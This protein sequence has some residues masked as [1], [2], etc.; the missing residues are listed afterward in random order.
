M[1]NQE[2]EEKLRQEKIELLKMKQGCGEALEEQPR[3]IEKPRGFK[4]ISN[5]FYHY[6]TVF[7][8]ALAA[9]A[10]AAVFAVQFLVKE[11]ADITVFV[12]YKQPNSEL[13]EKYLNIAAMLEKYCPDFDGDG[14]VNVAVRTADLS[15]DGDLTTDAAAEWSKLS[16]EIKL[17]ECP[18]IVC[19]GVF[20]EDIV[21]ESIAEYEEN[22]VLG[23]V[24]Q[25]KTAYVGK[26]ALSGNPAAELPEKTYFCVRALPVNQSG[27]KEAFAER[28]ERAQTV[29]QNLIDGNVINP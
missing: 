21:K 5:F 8:V 16:L 26:S 2:D 1:A 24:A 13:K 7:I 10:L 19:D 29:L 17:Y 14:K 28:R 15:V 3:V 20:L 6:K 23:E 4:K 18:L 27:D 9:A 12:A 22:P 11:K 25:D